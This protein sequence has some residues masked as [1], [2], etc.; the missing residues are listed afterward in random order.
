MKWKN[1]QNTNNSRKSTEIEMRYLIIKLEH[2]DPDLSKVDRVG[3][4]MYEAKDDDELKDQL[5]KEHIDDVSSR[6]K[7]KFIFYHKKLKVNFLVTILMNY[8]AYIDSNSYAG[9]LRMVSSIISIMIVFV[10]RV[11]YLRYDK[12]GTE[13]LFLPEASAL[14]ME[15]KE[16]FFNKFKDEYEFFSDK[17]CNSSVIRDFKVFEGIDWV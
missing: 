14:L 4:R 10:D 5:V 11:R 13:W 1:E 3:Y 6:M 9:H 15:D 17:N 2:I 12:N 8:R 16:Q 7:S